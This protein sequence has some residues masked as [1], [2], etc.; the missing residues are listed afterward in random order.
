MEFMATMGEKIAYARIEQNVTQEWLAEQ[1]GVSRQTISKWESDRSYP[2]I[3]KLFVLSQILEVSCDYLLNEDC[4]ISQQPRI[5][6]DSNGVSIDWTKMYP[7]LESYKEE[8][9]A[10]KYK[11]QFR[12]IFLELQ[13][14]HDYTE[15]DAM[16]V[17]KDL[18]ARA[19]FE[20]LEEQLI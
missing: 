6:G 15:E 9:D 10:E 20:Y 13:T 5:A 8:V 19:Y 14:Q 11:E 12:R 17:A 16:L 1:I 3:P 2:E 7:I 18:L 4:Q